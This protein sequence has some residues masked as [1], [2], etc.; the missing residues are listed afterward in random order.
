MPDTT[1]NRGINT[2][3]SIL[4]GKVRRAVVGEP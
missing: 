2:A 1:T 3:R 4:V